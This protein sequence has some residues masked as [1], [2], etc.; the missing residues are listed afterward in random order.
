MVTASLALIRNCTYRII[1]FTFL[2]PFLFRVFFT[3]KSNVASLSFIALHSTSFF[4]H[5]PEIFVQRKTG[6]QVSHLFSYKGRLWRQV[7]C[8]TGM[9]YTPYSKLRHS[10]QISAERPHC[11]WGQSWHWNCDKADKAPAHGKPLA[12]LCWVGN[13]QKA[14][15][16]EGLKPPS[17]ATDTTHELPS[18]W[19]SSVLMC[20]CKL[21]LN[22]QVRVSDIFAP[23]GNM[24]FC[25][26][27]LP[28]CLELALFVWNG[29]KGHKFTSYKANSDSS[30]KHMALYFLCKR[31]AKA[32]K[33]TQRQDAR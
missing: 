30:L 17:E 4:E 8:L 29:V 10:W 6:I 32:A 27:N 7:F 2:W 14:Q 15:R 13:G 25:L 24:W 12:T 9:I 19:A 20:T 18:L 1:F 3:S 23:I 22:V 31:R 16:G 28:A 33:Q 21:P 11:F 5:Q 26:L